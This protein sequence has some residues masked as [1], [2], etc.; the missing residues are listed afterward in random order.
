MQHFGLAQLGLNFNVVLIV[1]IFFKKEM[2]FIGRNMEL[3]SN[4][5]PPPGLP[6]GP[7]VQSTESRGK[8]GEKIL[9][10]AFLRLQFQLS[11]ENHQC[12][13]ATTKS[14]S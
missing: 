8:G 6:G 2:L 12:Q 1:F 3:I 4:L 7:P 5:F 11:P 13:L 9:Q 10:S 14:D